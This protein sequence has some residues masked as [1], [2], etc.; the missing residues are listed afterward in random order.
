M[1]VRYL[2][3]FQKTRKSYRCEESSNSTQF[4]TETCK[5]AD[6]EGTCHR[7]VASWGCTSGSCC[8][9]VEWTSMYACVEIC[10]PQFVTSIVIKYLK[11]NLY[12][13]RPQKYRS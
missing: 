12:M 10:E 4:L 8:Y 13:S 2:S 6:T 9:L 3:S 1:N 11:Y 7:N 5:M